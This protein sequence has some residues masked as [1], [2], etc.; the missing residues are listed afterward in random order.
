M[1][2]CLVPWATVG[3]HDLGFA[4]VEKRPNSPAWGRQSKPTV[5]RVAVTDVAA[6]VKEGYVKEIPVTVWREDI[7]GIFWGSQQFP[8]F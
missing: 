1:L 6:V 5:K 4:D 3:E 8:L 2:Y 7:L